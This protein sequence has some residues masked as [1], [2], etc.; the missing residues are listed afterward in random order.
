MDT[1]SIGYGWICQPC[2]TTSF[3]MFTSEEIAVEDA[4][5]HAGTKHA[6][7]LTGLT[8]VAEA[9]EDEDEDGWYEDDD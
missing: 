7:N 6:G 4:I 1:Y 5:K 2:N 9:F 8:V 3:I